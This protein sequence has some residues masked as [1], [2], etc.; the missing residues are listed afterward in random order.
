MA[1]ERALVAPRRRLDAAGTAV[2]LL[3]HKISP[4]TKQPAVHQAYKVHVHSFQCIYN[5][6][7]L[8]QSHKSLSSEEYWQLMQVDAAKRACSKTC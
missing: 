6:P 4:V 1:G 5:N 7:P 3:L 8:L 2:V